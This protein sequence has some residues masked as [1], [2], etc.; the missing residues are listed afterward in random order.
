MDISY[1]DRLWNK[2]KNDQSA[3]RT[4][5]DS[6]AEEFDQKGFMGESK[7]RLH[8]MLSF[9]TSERLVTEKSSILDIGCGPGK[10][11]VEF[12]KKADSVI[13]VDLSSRMVE[14]ANK[15]AVSEDLSNAE[16]IVADWADIDI[17]SMGW[18]KK[19]DLVVA[20]MCPAINSKEALEKMIRAS[21]G[22]CFFSSF[23]ERT[24]DIKDELGKLVSDR[25][26]PSKYGKAIY[27]GF[28]IL[29]LMG[30]H[31]EITYIDTQWEHM[32]PLNKAADFYCAHFAMTQKLS[33]EQ[34]ALIQ[35]YLE[36][37]SENGLVKETVKAKIAWMNWKVY[38]K[39][40]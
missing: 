40:T 35:E 37:V 1:F 29:W 18:D 12:A 13:G 26:A 24:D 36:Q 19:F 6:R 27:C 9:L 33:P 21:R 31:P 11:A 17:A 5:W 10:Y 16:F 38:Q 32:M 20:S 2:K 7:E 25:P 23:A 30:F 28:N 14:C 8:R 22:Y 34:K 39:E 3:S 4:F 15:N